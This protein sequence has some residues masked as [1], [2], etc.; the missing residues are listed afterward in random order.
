MYFLNE[1]TA[2]FYRLYLGFAL[3]DIDIN[4]EAI[5]SFRQP[6]GRHLMEVQREYFNLTIH[7][8]MPSSSL[9]ETSCNEA[10][11]VHRVTIP[12]ILRLPHCFAFLL[13]LVACIS[14]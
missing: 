2:S 8:Y 5:C 10:F 13:L 6:F 1:I 7:L 14:Y 11:F 3:S 4:N 9:D 12:Q